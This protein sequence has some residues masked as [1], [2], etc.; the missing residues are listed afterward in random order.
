MLNNTL[1]PLTDLSQTYTVEFNRDGTALRGHVVGRLKENGHRFLSN[2]ADASTLDQLCSTAIEPIG[3]SGYVRPDTEKE[4]RN[5][6]SFS[7]TSK[8]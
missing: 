4:G 5:L 1:M 7:R 8:L 3:R 6:F 2:H